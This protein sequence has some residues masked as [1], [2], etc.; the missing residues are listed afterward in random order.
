MG[1]LDRLRPASREASH[2][3]RVADA[4]RTFRGRQGDTIWCSGY[5]PVDA[6]GAAIAES[7]NRTSDP[8]VFHCLVA[9][10]HHNPKALADARFA[11]GSRITLRADPGNPS[12]PNAVGIWDASGTLQVGYVP[13]T[14][15]R[16][17]AAMIRR[18][19]QP[20]G[21]VVRELRLGSADGER[22]ALY[23]LIA[24]PGRIRLE[25]R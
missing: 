21:E 17:V 18:D 22:T 19:G 10:T 16:T 2:T 5:V 14:L 7:E 3:V 11:T 12:D 9:G 24:P 23:V 13:A 20:T 4:S 8:R 6:S 25:L 15:S 1:L